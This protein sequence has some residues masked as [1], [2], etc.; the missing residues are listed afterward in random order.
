MNYESNKNWCIVPTSVDWDEVAGTAIDKE[1]NVILFARGK[2]SVIVLNKQGEFIKTIGEKDFLRPHAVRVDSKNYLWFV[3]DGDHTVK[4]YDLDGNKLMTIGIPNSP[5][6][7]HSGVPFNRCTDVAIDYDTE[8]IFI[9]DGYGN[10]NVH[11]FSINGEFIKS[12]GSPGTDESQFNI[13]HNI[14]IDANGYLYVA[15]RENHRVQIFDQGGAFVDQITNMHRPCAL[16]IHNDKL[17]VGELGY[18]MSVNQ[19]VPNIGPRISVYNLN[20]ELLFRWGEGFGNNP[21]QLYAPHSI[22]IDDDG[23]IYLGEVSKTNMQNIGLDAVKYKG[24]RY[25]KYLN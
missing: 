9:S 2:T 10:S 19:N 18:G 4:K 3:D 14:V 12:W 11:K 21:N 6:E 13:V 17:Y 1:G 24:F 25:L 16:N 15:D 5:A 22:A 7:L 8:S 23:N 20:K